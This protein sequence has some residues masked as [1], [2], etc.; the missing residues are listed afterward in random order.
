MIIPGDCK[1]GLSPLPSIGTSP[2]T[3]ANGLPGKATMNKKNPAVPIRTAPAPPTNLELRA[4]ALA[5]A[6]AEKP[7]RR[8]VQNNNE[9]SIPPH[10]ALIV[11]GTLSDR[12]V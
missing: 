12:D 10:S 8:V 11:Y 7:V 5:I 9:P 6:R 4:G 2:A 3:G 1:S